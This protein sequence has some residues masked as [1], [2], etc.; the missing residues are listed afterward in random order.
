MTGVFAGT[1]V[2]SFEL[3]K[4][5]EFSVPTVGCA[6]FKSQFVLLSLK[7]CSLTNVEHRSLSCLHF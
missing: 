2:V 4:C 3:T 1:G 7:R 6:I 5:L